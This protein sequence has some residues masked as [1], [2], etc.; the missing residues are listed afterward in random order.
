MLRGPRRPGIK[1]GPAALPQSDGRPG[2]S[3]RSCFLQPARLSAQTLPP[4][5]GPRVLGKGSTGLP[6]CSWGS[7][8]KG[9]R[10]GDGPRRWSPGGPEP[11]GRLRRRLRTEAG[12]WLLSPGG[13][14]SWGR[15]RAVTTGS[16]RTG[17]GLSL[18]LRPGCLA[19]LTLWPCPGHPLWEPFVD[20]TPPPHPGPD[21]PGSFPA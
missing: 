15:V 8:G 16:S 1:P 13:P 14:C 12:P 4:P 2:G 10:R 20:M 5:P 11:P 6:A 17:Q 9:V 19:L 21:F 18:P 7:G 3:F